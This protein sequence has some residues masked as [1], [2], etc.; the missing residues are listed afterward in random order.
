LKGEAGHAYNV[1]NEDTY[2]S[3]KELAECVKL[4]INS[5]IS[6][7]TIINNVGCYAATSLLPLSTE[8]LRSLGWH[9]QYG[10]QELLLN[11][12]DYIKEQNLEYHN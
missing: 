2:K 5:N 9:P 3:I 1:A 12:A 7:K 11:L 4:T 10:I 8:K 6:V